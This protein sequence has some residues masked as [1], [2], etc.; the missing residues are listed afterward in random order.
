MA[1]LM[2]GQP[3]FP[4]ESGIDQL[5]EIIKVLGT[6]TRD[7]IRKVRGKNSTQ[8][9]QSSSRSLQVFRKADPNAIDLISKLLEY[10]PTQRLSAIDAMVHPFF[11]ELRDPSTRLPDSRHPNGA[12]RDM[13]E[14]YNFTLHGTH[15][16]P[17]CESNKLTCP[18]LSIAPH[19][20]QQLVPQHIRAALT[21][22]GLDFESPNF[23]PLT[24]DQMLARLD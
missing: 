5:V 12:T 13:P 6:P 21:S 22:R 2:L 8:L 17:Q 9:E 7:Q 15:I 18:E 24:R 3:L 1:E 16:I 19:L 20:N 14:L 10:T 23:K 4:G 11:D